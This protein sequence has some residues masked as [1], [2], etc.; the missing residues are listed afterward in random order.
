MSC[1]IALSTKN[2]DYIGEALPTNKKLSFRL[3]LETKVRHGTPVMETGAEHH[4][5]QVVRKFQVPSITGDRVFTVNCSDTVM[6]WAKHNNPELCELL[7]AIRE[8]GKLDT[9]IPVVN[10]TE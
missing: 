5:A 2:S 9:L 7:T 4:Q 3:G 6:V 1:F 10:V 8:A